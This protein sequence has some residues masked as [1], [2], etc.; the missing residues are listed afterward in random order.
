MSTKTT[1]TGETGNVTGST[2]YKPLFAAAGVADAA[3]EA[4]R[5]LPSKIASM[6]TDPEFRAELRSRLDK[7]P[8]EAKSLRD[9]VPAFFKDAQTKA[10]E[11]PEKLKELFGHASTDF[12]KAYDDLAVRGED[13]VAKFKSEYGDTVDSA[14]SSIRGKAAEAADEIADAAEDAA[15][16]IK[17]RSAK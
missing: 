11:V 17:K 1:D 2:E 14:I 9:D 4:L 10:S 15:D 8:E 7:L 12:A 5:E 16:A 3:V 13:A 6:A